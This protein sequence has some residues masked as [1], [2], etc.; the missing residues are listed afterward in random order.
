MCSFQTNREHFMFASSHTASYI[1]PALCH[2]GLRKVILTHFCLDFRRYFWH[3]SIFC[4]P[5]CFRR[6][7][8]SYGKGISS[9]P[10]WYA[11]RSGKKPVGHGSEQIVWKS[12][13]MASDKVQQ[14]LKR[15]A[16]GNVKDAVWLGADREVLLYWLMRTQYVCVVRQY[17]RTFMSDT[18]HTSF[19]IPWT[20]L[21]RIADSSCQEPCS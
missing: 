7:Q 10:H 5:R 1:T 3:T 15:A 8:S 18:R 21:Y 20:A 14:K 4:V 2:A 12:A 16:H 11:W 19:H 17:S 6:P 9:L 13:D